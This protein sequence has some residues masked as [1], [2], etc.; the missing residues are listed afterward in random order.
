[1]EGLMRSVPRTLAVP[2]IGTDTILGKGVTGVVFCASDAYNERMV[3]V[4]QGIFGSQFVV[5]VYRKNELW[6]N[7][8]RE[9]DIY[10]ALK[11]AAHIVP[12]VDW[13]VSYKAPGPDKTII[14]RVNVFDD[15]SKVDRG[16]TPHLMLYY[17]R[18]SDKEIVE[19]NQVFPIFNGPLL[20]LI[21]SPA[22]TQVSDYRRLRMCY[23][24]A[25]GMYEMHRRGVFHNDFHLNNILYRLERDR[26]GS[27]YLAVHDLGHAV[28]ESELVPGRSVELPE[29]YHQ[30]DM[31][32][33]GSVMTAICVG[34]YFVELRARNDAQER[35]LAK[36]QKN[37]SK[38]FY[39]MLE[40][41]FV[42]SITSRE[43]VEMLAEIIPGE[44]PRTHT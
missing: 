6:Y 43:V 20:R 11:G 24:V 44:R 1:M 9:L 27:F 10:T 28:L 26:P 12:M 8:S 41:C 36:L 16:M 21:Q 19:M 37:F 32:Q 14:S 4:S 5:K 42:G 34:I 40:K 30:K 31:E 39:Q 3:L 18:D 23:Q 7:F 33:L 25:F 38:K 15:Y 22:F 35:A 13:T 2:E 17:H 29:F